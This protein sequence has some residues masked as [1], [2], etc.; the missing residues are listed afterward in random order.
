MRAHESR[1][2]WRRLPVDQ[3]E[4][5]EAESG[6]GKLSKS[7]GLWQLTAIGVGGIIGVGIFSLA[8][9]V[10]HGD[11]DNPGSDPPYS[12]PSSSPASHQRPQLCPTPSSPA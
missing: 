6:V 8:G 1:S 10:A 12:S 2:V 4:E 5:I 3:I 7:L 9:L 11:A